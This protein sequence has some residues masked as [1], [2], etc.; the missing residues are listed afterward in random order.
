MVCKNL[1]ECFPSM[2]FVIRQKKHLTILH[3]TDWELD[4]S[5]PCAVL[6]SPPMI[7]ILKKTPFPK[8]RG[9]HG[10]STPSP[11]RGSCLS[12][13]KLV[14]FVASVRW[15]LLIISSVC[16]T[17]WLH[18]LM[19]CEVMIGLPFQKNM[20]PNSNPIVW[21]WSTFWCLF[22]PVGLQTTLLMT[23]SMNPFPSAFEALRCR[24]TS[25]RTYLSPYGNTGYHFVAVGNILS[26]RVALM[27]LLAASCGLRF[28]L[29]QPSGSFLEDLPRFQWL[30]GRLKVLF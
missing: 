5:F 29:E 30:W 25:G 18:L 13:S 26:T 2:V 21:I 7:M 27:C 23:M 19:T 22:W 6:L 14:G 12:L 3:N 20:A 1:G 9:V 28:L 8:S 10:V 17:W 24:H 4:V 15:E 11:H 16:T